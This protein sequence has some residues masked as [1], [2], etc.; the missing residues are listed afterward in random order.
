[1]E[2]MTAINEVRVVRVRRGQ[3]R[4]S[5]MAD[6]RKV[7]KRIRMKHI[8]PH[9]EGFQIRISFKG[10]IHGA[11]K[12]FRHYESEVECLAATIEKRD[13]ILDRL[14]KP[15]SAGTVPMASVDYLSKRSSSNTGYRGIYYREYTYQKR[16]IPQHTKVVDVG[17]WN[18]ALGE[19]GH[20]KVA[21]KKEGGRAKAIMAARR[22][23]K[24]LE[25]IHGVAC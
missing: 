5:S 22:L 16:G 23:Q 25:E 12:A 20:T 15:L 18:K 1:M 11:W 13:E 6:R 3:E 8:S 9:P 2:P 24:E 21:V 14:K 10:K 19:F 7:L 17:W 4:H